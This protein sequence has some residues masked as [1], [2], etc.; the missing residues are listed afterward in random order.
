[1]TNF[2]DQIIN[3]KFSLVVSLP[4]NRIDFAEAAI[5]GGAQ[6]IKIHLN[7]V[8]RASGN[9]FGDLEQNIGFLKEL[10]AIAGD[11]PVGVVPGAQEAFITEGELSTLE[12]MGVSFFSS[13]IHH[14]PPFMMDSKSLTKMVAI[15]NNYD[16]ALIKAIKSSPIDVLEGSIIPGEDYGTPLSYSDLLRYGHL[17]LE[18][19]KPLLI[20]SQKKIKPR[21]VKYLYDQGCKALMIGAVVTGG[22]DAEK[23]KRATASFR[24]VIEG[25]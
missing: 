7:L 11:I 20:P 17:A 10:I 5:E 22:D 6:A 15:D 16:D 13:Y 21:E 4:D 14:L 25:L 2:K 8:H 24:E 19:D 9:G 12:E 3:N 18:A 23:I 1:M